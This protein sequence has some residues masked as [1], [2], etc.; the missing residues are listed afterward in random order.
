MLVAVTLSPRRL[1][2]AI[3]L[4]TLACVVLFTHVFV[5]LDRI[6]VKV[7]QTPVTATAGR[8]RVTTAGFRQ[9]KALQPRSR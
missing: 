5:A 3:L 8:V 6:R 2:G 9:V 4:S 1:V 7:V